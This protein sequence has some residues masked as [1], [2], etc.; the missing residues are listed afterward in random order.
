MKT[1]ITTLRRIANRLGFSVYPQSG[2]W[3]LSARKTENLH[4]SVTTE[5]AALLVGLQR[6]AEGDLLTADESDAV[7]N[8]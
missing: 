7:A 1:R 8:A 5:R 2:G 3:V 4:Y 6:A